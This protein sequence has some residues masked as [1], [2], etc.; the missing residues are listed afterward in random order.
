MNTHPGGQSS[1]LYFN[2]VPFFWTPVLNRHMWQLKTVVSLHWYL[3][4]AFLLYW[5][6]FT[7]ILKQNKIPASLKWCLHKLFVSAISLSDRIWTGKIRMTSRFQTF[8]DGRISIEIAS[9]SKIARFK[10]RVW[11]NL[12][13]IISISITFLVPFDLSSVLTN[14]ASAYFIV[15][16]IAK[17]TQTQ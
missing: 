5:S 7:E 13:K 9:L 8:Q 12:Y 16:S 14:I 1:N 15:L 3:I 4:C 17:H 11:M 2:V 6:Q 10:S